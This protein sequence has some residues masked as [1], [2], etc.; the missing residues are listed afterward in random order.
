[1]LRQ[2]TVRHT[3]A[4]WLSLREEAGVPCGPVNTIE[5][6]FADPQVYAR[7]LRV[8]V[9]HPEAGLVPLVANPMR[10]SATPVS[11]RLP[12]PGLGQH[13]D[14]VLADWLGASST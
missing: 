9:P 11:Y 4:D 10:L 14:E 2:A 3:T 7:A 12:P 1:M 5:Q 8:E 6:V 13:T